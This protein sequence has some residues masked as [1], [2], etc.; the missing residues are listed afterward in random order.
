MA[1]HK[2][3]EKRARQALKRRLRNRQAKSQIRTA[4]K[5]MRKFVD[6][7]QIE[8]AKSFLPELISLIQ[9]KS[10]RGILHK[11]TASRYVSRMTRLINKAAQN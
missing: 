10:D 2:S 3:A 4:M 7:N 8:E 6:E 1:N 5:K 9:K 11:N